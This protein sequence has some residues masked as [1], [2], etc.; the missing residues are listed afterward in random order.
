MFYS[1]ELS[2]KFLFIASHFT[3]AELADDVSEKADDEFSG[4]EA[5]PPFKHAKLE[6]A[7][8]YSIC[9]KHEDGEFDVIPESFQ[10]EIRNFVEAKY[11]PAVF[12][13]LGDIFPKYRRYSLFMVEEYGFNLLSFND[14]IT[15]EL[16]YDLTRTES[17]LSRPD[18]YT[19]TIRQGKEAI[20]TV[21]R[22]C[23]AIN[24]EELA[25]EIFQIVKNC[26]TPDER[27]DPNNPND[28]IRVLFGLDVELS[29]ELTQ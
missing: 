21:M 26:F 29:T 27:R 13:Y 17:F 3:P 12:K 9:L 1:S 4:I 11:M 22:I 28:P 7:D 19:R 14:G 6:E 25:D 23:K 18:I 10:K 15:P 16:A 2:N 24:K 8:D 5:G 20:G